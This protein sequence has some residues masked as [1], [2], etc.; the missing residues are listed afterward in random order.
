MKLRECL[1]RLSRK[2]KLVRN[3]LAAAVFLFLLEWMMNFPCL[4]AEGLLRRAERMYLLEDTELLYDGRDRGAGGV[5]WPTVYGRKVDTLLAV[6]YGRSPLG[7]QLLTVELYREPDNIH[8]FRQMNFFGE[9]PMRV[10]AFGDLK[11]ADRAE[12]LCTVEV[13]TGVGDVRRTLLHETYVAEGERTAP[14][15]MAF[16]LTPHY[17]EED[18][19]EAAV[20]ERK[21]FGDEV[22]AQNYDAVL[23]LYDEAGRLLHE[24]R[25]EILEEES[26]GW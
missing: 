14:E 25:V 19:S 13:T 10:L 22:A 7:R 18:T 15:T 8:C 20:T 24:K 6:R 26:Y 5:C 11:D 12:L 23:R 17:G 4:T 3:L 21:L 2:Q 9:R 16:T 1:P